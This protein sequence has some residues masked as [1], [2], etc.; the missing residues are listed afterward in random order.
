MR[1]SSAASSPPGPPPLP[2]A[3]DGRGREE[4]LARRGAGS[5]SLSKSRP[6]PRPKSPSSLADSIPSGGM[7]RLAA[8]AGADAAVR[9]PSRPS[10][11][12]PL[13]RPRL[14]AVGLAQRRLGLGVGHEALVVLGVLEVGLGEHPVSAGPRIGGERAVFLL[15][16][17]RG[18][19]QA[20]GGPV[21]VEHL[22]AQ[23]RVGVRAAARTGVA[24]PAARCVGGSHAGPFCQEGA[25][26]RQP[27]AKSAPSQGRAREAQ[28]GKGVGGS[29]R[30]KR[31]QA[32]PRPPRPLRPLQ[33]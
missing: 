10:R 14:G 4:R 20:A 18:A 28:G 11:P 33:A 22:G 3:R 1:L 8:A 16:L 27:S 15:Q 13:A 12:W 26:G 29:A 2:L 21:G 24:A 30:Q 19:A 25:G 9:R 23:R 5:G 31:A 17:R 7:S 32:R 6:S